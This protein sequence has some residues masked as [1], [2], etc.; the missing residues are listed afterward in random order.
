M[1]QP[2]KAPDAASELPRVRARLIASC[3]MFAIISIPLILRLVPPNGLYG[4]RTGSTMSSPAIWY[5]A[6]AFMGWTLLL[7]AVVSATLLVMLPA[8]AKRW[9]LWVALWVPVLGSIAA[10]FAYLNRLG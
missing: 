2:R 3:V 7:A 4:F 10:S 6:N 1:I 5:P 8:T 9:V